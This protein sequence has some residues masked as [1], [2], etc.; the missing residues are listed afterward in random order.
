[1][2]CDDFKNCDDGSDEL[3]CDVKHNCR[4]PQKYFCKETNICI[5]AGNVFLP[6]F[7]W[8][9]LN[10]MNSDKVCVDPGFCDIQ[11]DYQYSYLDE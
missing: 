10:K 2:E 9:G 5:A 7:V 3:N 6:K 11:N 8:T 4:G 1:M